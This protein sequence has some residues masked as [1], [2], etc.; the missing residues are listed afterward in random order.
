LPAA[1]VGWLSMA[2]GLTVAETDLGWQELLDADEIFLTN[3]QI[4]VIAVTRCG[5]RTWPGGALT[6]QCMRL[7][8]ENGV[9]ECQP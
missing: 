5:E 7:A 3:S 6:R 1:V 9:P 8:A 4:G 2:A